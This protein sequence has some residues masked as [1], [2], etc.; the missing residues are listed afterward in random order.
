[1]NDDS[2]KDTPLTPTETTKAIQ[3]VADSV[4]VGIGEHST[5]V[6]L[7]VVGSEEEYERTATVEEENPIV[8]ANPLLDL[9]AIETDQDKL[10]I[11]CEDVAD[12]EVEELKRQLH[13][14]MV[15]LG[16]QALGLSAIQIGIPKRAFV[17]RVPLKDPPMRLSTSF[18][19]KYDLVFFMNPVINKTQYPNRVT[20]SCLSIPRKE[21]HVERF[22]R[23]KMTDDINGEQ[24]YKNKLAQVIQHE[25]DHTNG[26]TLYQSGK[27]IEV[28]VAENAKIKPEFLSSRERISFLENLAKSTSEISGKPKDAIML[29]EVPNKT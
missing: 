19:K 25:F 29:D 26:I 21:F 9:V 27:C 12:D 7:P 5:G 2:K 17:V 20:E 23:V 8:L 18:D 4:V 11:V 28:E 24:L 3:K 6:H 10:T 13:A 14:H 1:M 15:L 22:N 16:E